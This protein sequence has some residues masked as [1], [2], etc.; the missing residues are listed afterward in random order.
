ML[1]PS[2]VPLSI[3]GVQYRGRMEAS[4]EYFFAGDG[5]LDPGGARPDML[6][7]QFTQLSRGPVRVLS[8][9]TRTDIPLVGA[10]TMG[11]PLALKS[12]AA[13]L[14]PSSDSFGQKQPVRDAETL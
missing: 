7:T 13:T 12:T 5:S 11:Y 3:T 4:A 8:D 10:A 6:A 1:V 14:M 2:S 9:G